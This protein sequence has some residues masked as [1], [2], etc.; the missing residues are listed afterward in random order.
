MAGAEHEASWSQYRDQ[1]LRSLFE[2]PLRC[3]ARQYNDT[4]VQRRAREGARRRLTRA[5]AARAG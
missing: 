5:S 4:V 1:F 3:H 2:Y